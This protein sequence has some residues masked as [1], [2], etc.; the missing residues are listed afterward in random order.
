MSGLSL[1]AFGVWECTLDFFQQAPSDAPASEVGMH[2][3]P[4]QV[5]GFPK[6]NPRI[7]PMIL[8]L[9]TAFRNTIRSASEWPFP[10][11]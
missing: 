9:T 2:N 3:H 7:E 8:P 6:A 4:T 11:T 10:G 5:G 1:E